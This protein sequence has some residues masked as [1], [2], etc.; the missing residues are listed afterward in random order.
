MKTKQFYFG[1]FVAFMATMFAACSSSDEVIHEQSNQLKLSAGIM[2]QKE[3]YDISKWGTKIELEDIDATTAKES[4]F[5]L[6]DAETRTPVDNNNWVGMANRNL[7]VQVGSNAPD[8]SSIDA[9]GNI[10]MANPYYFTT[11]N[12]VSL[13]AWYPYSATLTSFSVQTDQSSYA[14]YEKSDLMYASATV[15]Q[16]VPMG[17]LTFSHKNAKVTFNVTV[18][19]TNNLYAAT[20][21]SAVTLS[22]V[23]I[24]ESVS[25][26]AVSNPSTSSSLKMYCS[27]ASSISNNTAT[28]TFEACLVPQ[29]TAI[30]YVINY[31]SGTYSGELDSKTLSSG[32]QYTCNVILNVL[33]TGT[34]N[35]YTWV[36]LGLPSKLRWANMNIGA[37]SATDYGKYYCWGATKECVGV[38][39]TVYYSAEQI[40]N[41]KLD[42]PWSIDNPYGPYSSVSVNITP[43]GGHDVARNLWG[44]QWRMSTNEEFIELITYCTWKKVTENGHLGYRVTGK[45][46]NSIFLPAAG[47]YYNGTFYNNWHGGGKT[48][49]EIGLFY[50]SS[51]VSH[52]TH[53]KALGSEQ[54]ILSLGGDNCGNSYKVEGHTIRPVISF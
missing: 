10:T 21:I 42:F 30:K 17:N 40:S 3:P 22:N 16:S 44:N 43:T 45:N 31:G 54:K 23:C 37:T 2:A 26:G 41:N 28:A 38:D 51:T 33:A 50:W 8:K 11:L 19:G 27:K 53:A 25:D 5:E 52:E 14:N 34:I 48:D 18:T 9:S 49:E 12:N 46:G 1:I 47:L 15:N 6:S 35:G 13:K 7:S 20:N 4:K 29:T 32:R 36:R 39:G 24:S